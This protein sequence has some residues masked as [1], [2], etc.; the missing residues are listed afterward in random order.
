MMTR[1]LS[2][3]FPLIAATRYPNVQ[4][5]AFWEGLGNMLT[6]VLNSNVV[7][8]GISQ[9]VP[10]LINNAIGGQS[11]TNA[12]TAGTPNGYTNLGNGIYVNP[13]GQVVNTNTTTG[14][15]QMQG[16]SM[17]LPT[18][19]VPAAMVAGAGLVLYLVLKKK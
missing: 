16:A 8:T 7:Q 14:Q 18:W 10:Q 1:K 12:N 9:A 5:F 2:V 17:G 13:A 11:P 6:T 15:M 3:A 19:F 4:G